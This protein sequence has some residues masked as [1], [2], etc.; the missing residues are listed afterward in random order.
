MLCAGVLTATA[1]II[2]IREKARPTCIG[3]QQHL[4][5]SKRMVSH[6]LVSA[7][8]YCHLL[9]LLLLL[10]QSGKTPNPHP[11][12]SEK[13]KGR[14]RGNVQSS[15]RSERSCSCGLGWDLTSRHVTVTRFVC[16]Q[17]RAMQART[18]LVGGLALLN[19]GAPPPA[20]PYNSPHDARLSHV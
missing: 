17:W 12:L 5:C 13:G 18:P 3:F 1:V 6:A 16:A 20:C 9:L 15:G 14:E 19:K 8:N 2:I 11:L 7:N 10:Q 4:H